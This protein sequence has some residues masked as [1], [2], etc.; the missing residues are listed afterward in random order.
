M[1]KLSMTLAPPIRRFDFDVRS[2][3]GS[4]TCNFGA[5]VHKPANLHSA[6]GNMSAAAAS[7]SPS[8]AL[9]LWHV[10]I[11]MLVT[12]FA[13]PQLHSVAGRAL[14]QNMAVLQ[15]LGSPQSWPKQDINVF[16]I[17]SVYLDV[18]AVV[19]AGSPAGHNPE[20]G[21]TPTGY[22][23]FKQEAFY[24][25]CWQSR[26]DVAVVMT[27][28]LSACRRLEWW[29][30]KDEKSGRILMVTPAWFKTYRPQKG[31]SAEL[32]P[33]ADTPDT[34]VALYLPAKLIP[35]ICW[36]AGKMDVAASIANWMLERPQDTILTLA[37]YTADLEM[38]LLTALLE[39]EG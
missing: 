6:L 15:G 35:D 25:M 22:V 14:E 19:V 16:D 34:M 5:S 10:G 29:T 4:R 28:S 8:E 18:A 12:D 3:F 20:G 30:D 9:V 2:H 37:A 11:R 31:L 21:R 17:P 13:S 23:S 24:S 39:F 36:T 26:A 1:L 27:F 7:S 38:D 32:T 33:L